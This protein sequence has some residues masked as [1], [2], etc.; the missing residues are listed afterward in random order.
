MDSRL[1][2]SD[3]PLSKT[4]PERE[5]ERVCYIIY[6]LL[7]SFVDKVKEKVCYSTIINIK[8]IEIFLL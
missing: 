6:E 1:T 5:R 3:C 2:S 7:N 4:F 8:I